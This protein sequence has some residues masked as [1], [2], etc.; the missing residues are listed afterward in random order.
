[1]KSKKNVSLLTIGYFNSV[2]SQD[3]LTNKVMMGYQ[4]WF[5][6]LGDGSATNNPWD[7]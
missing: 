6:A 1:M 3:Q 7:H 4:G 5:L 2:S